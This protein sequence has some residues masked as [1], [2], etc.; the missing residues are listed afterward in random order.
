MEITIHQAEES[1]KPLFDAMLQDYAENLL[2]YIEIPRNPENRFDYP[3]LDLYWQ[4]P[5]DRFP[6]LIHAD[7]HVAGFAFVNR[8]FNLVDPDAW[9]IEEFFVT[10]DYRRHGIGREA[11]NLVLSRFPGKWEVAVIASNNPALLF[12][13]VVIRS[14]AAN[15]ITLHDISVGNVAFS[16]FTFRA[17][18]PAVPSKQPLD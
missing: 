8:S 2:S 13:D 6:F 18:T 16:V 9:S 11:A 5:T 10:P 1:Q 4:D 7:A 15:D 12:W 17:L 3:E 14:C